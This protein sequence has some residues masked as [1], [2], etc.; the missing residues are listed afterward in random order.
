MNNPN[1]NA[2]EEPV[3]HDT[4]MVLIDGA[5]VE[6]TADDPEIRQ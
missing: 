4:V 3:A 6:V 2:Y 5:L 1:E